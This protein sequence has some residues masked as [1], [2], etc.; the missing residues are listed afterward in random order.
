VTPR[1]IAYACVQ[2]RNLLFIVVFLIIFQT[3]IA[4]SNM[5]RWKSADGLFHLDQFYE[6]IVSIF[7]DNPSTPWAAETL[8]W[9]NR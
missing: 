5:K 3:Y 4:L 2:V 6:D 8:E 9:W 1:T 7:D